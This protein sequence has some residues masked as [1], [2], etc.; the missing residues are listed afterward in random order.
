MHPFLLRHFADFL[1]SDMCRH[2]RSCRC[3]GWSF[4]VGT[5]SSNC[6]ERLKA[7]TFL[8]V[9]LSSFFSIFHFQFIP[10]LLQFNLWFHFV[11]WFCPAIW[12][13]FFHT[14]LSVYSCQYERVWK[15]YMLTYIFQLQGF[16]STVIFRWNLRVSCSQLFAAI[17]I[18]WWTMVGDI[19]LSYSLCHVKTEDS[20]TIWRQKGT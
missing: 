6:R 12:K 15:K 8:H 20:H 7:R 11:N 16:I 3:S 1:F 14:V 4:V 10:E 19:V 18:W 5:L 13:L 17:F 9:P 2:F